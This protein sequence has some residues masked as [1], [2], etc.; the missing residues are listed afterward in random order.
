MKSASKLNSES[1]VRVGCCSG[2]IPAFDLY[3][4]VCP[5]GVVPTSLTNLPMSSGIRGSSSVCSFSGKDDVCPGE[6][7]LIFG[8]NARFSG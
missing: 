6:D 4:F 2:K 5:H 3:A 8:E 7:H 1:R